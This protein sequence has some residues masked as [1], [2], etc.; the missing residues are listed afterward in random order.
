MF[1]FYG[2]AIVDER[3]GSATEAIGMS[4]NLVSKNVGQLLL[5]F[6]LLLVINFGGAILCG[7]GL[8]FTYPLTAVAVAFAWRRI[9][10]GPVAALA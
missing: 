2:Y 4:W 8:L 3:T 9:S 5:L 6:I 1:A 7:I 10:G